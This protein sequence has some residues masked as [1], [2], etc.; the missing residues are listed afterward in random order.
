MRKIYQQEKVQIKK[1]PHSLIKSRNTAFSRFSRKIF[2]STE[3]NINT[4]QERAFFN[5]P[6][7]RS[8]IIDQRKLPPGK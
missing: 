7:Y 5:E 3:V 1:K 4:S 6:Q 8:N 2:T